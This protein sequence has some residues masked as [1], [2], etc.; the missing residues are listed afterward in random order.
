MRKAILSGLAWIFGLKAIF[1]NPQIVWLRCEAQ[2]LVK[3]ADKLKDV[4]G[5]YRR[6]QVYGELV[7]RHPKTP[8]WQ[9][10]LSIE[11]AVALRRRRI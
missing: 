10:G 4:G 5:E 11:T 3:E 9:I 7:K 1:T 2:G 6:F 8:K